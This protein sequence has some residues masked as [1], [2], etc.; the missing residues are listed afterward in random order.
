VHFVRPNGGVVVPTS[1][2]P[3]CCH[4]FFAMFGKVANYFLMSIIILLL[5]QDMLSDFC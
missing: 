1:F 5:L 3:V 2:V 4:L